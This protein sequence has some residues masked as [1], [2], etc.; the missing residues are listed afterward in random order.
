MVDDSQPLPAPRGDDMRPTDAT[1]PF[2]A[3]PGTRDRSI[4]RRAFIGLLSAGAAAV[5]IGAGDA[6]RSTGAQPRPVRPAS[7]GLAAQMSNETSPP[8][9][10]SSRARTVAE[11][12]ATPHFSVAHRGCDRSWPEMSL[13]AYEHSVGA[14]FDAL[15]I[16]LARTVDGVW[17]GLH[18]DALDRTSHVSGKTASDMTWAQVQ[19]YRIL[20]ANAVD[21]PSQ[22]DRPYMRWEELIDRYYGSHVIFVD[23]KSAVTHA[24]DLLTM[25]SRLPGTPQDRFV[26]KGY[27]ISG[28]AD[29]STGWAR[30]AMDNGF[31]RWGYFYES[32]V[33]RLEAYQGRWD[34]L[35]MSC[36]APDSAWSRVRAFGKPVI[37]HVAPSVAA[38]EIAL[39]RGAVGVIA[40]D[41]SVHSGR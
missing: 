37:G 27:G 24:R 21:D 33:P 9:A 17:F 20:G 14:G 19:E 23:P 32:D 16:S 15:E 7:P 25:M 3:P 22:P 38:A 30:L 6:L 13:Y 28:E 11:L 18:D 36:S 29:N 34:I 40:S 39:A 8:L 41:A 2:E 26:C 31:S 35:G 10:R 5:V 12:L 4:G 1:E